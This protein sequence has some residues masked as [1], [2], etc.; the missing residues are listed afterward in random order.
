MMQGTQ[1]NNLN[2]IGL[3]AF[4]AKISARN[5]LEFIS[6]H[7]EPKSFWGPTVSFRWAR[8]NVLCHKIF[9]SEW[10]SGEFGLITNS[11]TAVQNLDFTTSLF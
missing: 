7:L 9:N 4:Y 1:R 8:N 2:L 11:K 6:E 5:H 3:G 10:G